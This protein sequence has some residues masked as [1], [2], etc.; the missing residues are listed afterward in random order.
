M[1]DRNRPSL[2]AASLYVL[3][4]CTNR[5]AIVLLTVRVP[6][7]RVALCA[8]FFLLPSQGNYMSSMFAIRQRAA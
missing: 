4:N 5:I 2:Q 3:G 7:P 8:S 1:L 6:T